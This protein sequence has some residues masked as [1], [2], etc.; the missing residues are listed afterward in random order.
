MKDDTLK[1]GHLIAV[2]LIIATIYIAFVGNATVGIGGFIAMAV[3][4]AVPVIITIFLK[5]PYKAFVY[6][7][8][9]MLL[10]GMS[11]AGQSGYSLSN[12]PQNLEQCIISKMKGQPSSMQAIVVRECRRHFKG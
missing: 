5:K 7:I 11:I 10:C 4:A 1:S 8:S 2:T 6:I 12:N 9:L 3:L